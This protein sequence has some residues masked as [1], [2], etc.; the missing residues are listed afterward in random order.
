MLKIGILFPGYGSQYIGMGKNFYDNYRIVQD[1]FEDASYCLET[2]F[3]KLCFAGSYEEISKLHN[4][5]K[6]IFLT[7]YSIASVIKNELNIDIS[8][9]GGYGIGEY[10]AMAFSGGLNLP[11]ALYLLK[12]A[13]E[14]YYS[15]NIDQ[16]IKSLLIYGISYEELN[17]LNISKYGISITF[18]YYNHIVLSGNAERLNEFYQ[19]INKKFKL[20]YIDFEN[21]L[22]TQ[23]ANIITEQLKSYI[24][25]V[26]FRNLNIPL[27]SSVNQ[28]Y[29]MYAN[30]CKEIF[31][32]FWNNPLNWD[33]VI[34]SFQDIDIIIIPSPSKQLYKRI[35]DIFLNKN[36]FAIESIDNI[37]ELKEFI[38]TIY[39][40][41]Y[42]NNKY[43]VL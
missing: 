43:I 23:N 8:L 2:N 36:I 10:S 1:L 35:K 33:S 37:E 42:N 13:T 9:V 5:Y 6:S 32:N 41:S 28:R 39:S 38:E 19:I 27:I 34:S 4:A 12:K 22:H 14:F 31:L 29:I 24:L 7:S 15:F 21:G 30:D 18:N 3:V 17:N 25:K 16:D 26:D 40:K 11:D 20:K